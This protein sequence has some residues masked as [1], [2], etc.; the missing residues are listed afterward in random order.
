MPVTHGVAGSSPV[1]TARSLEEI[2]GFFFYIISETVDFAYA[3]SF[4]TTYLFACAKRNVSLHKT[5][6]ISA[7]HSSKLVDFALDLHYLFI[8]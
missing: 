1:R 8:R 5:S 6:C 3:N 4:C 2:Q 7:K